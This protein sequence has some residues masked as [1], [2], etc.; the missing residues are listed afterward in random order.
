[1]STPPYLALPPG[2]RR[3]DLAIPRGRV[4]ALV[5][6]LEPE[7][8]GTA[9]LVPGFTGSKEDFIAVLAPLTQRGWRVVAIDQRGQLDSLGGTDPAEFSL[10]AL[11]GDLIEVL[12]HLGVAQVHLVGHSFGGLVAR[13]GALVAPGRVASLTLLG[14]GPGPLPEPGRSRVAGMHRALGQLDLESIWQ[15]GQELDAEAG[16]PAP[17]PQMLE[18]L[19]RRFLANNPVALRAMAQALLDTA[20]RSD[21]LAEQATRVRMRLLVAHGVDDEPWPPAVQ[22]GMARRIGADYVVIPGCA[23]SPAAEAPQATVEVLD[24]FWAGASPGLSPLRR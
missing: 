15:I 4:A 12:D 1:M 18:F 6:D 22:A 11:G 23:H 8:A 9:L 14:S 13:A 20:D 2:I 16:Q 3:L 21:E 7:P 19:H 5:G 17:D 10:E 24:W